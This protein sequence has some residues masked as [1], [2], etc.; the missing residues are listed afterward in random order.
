MLEYDGDDFQ[1]VFSIAFE[2]TELWVYKF[3]FDS[4]H[5]LQIPRKKLPI[6]FV[7]RSVTG[8]CDKDD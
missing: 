4:D 7:F 2:V 5:G 3:S 1:D 6:Q 8:F